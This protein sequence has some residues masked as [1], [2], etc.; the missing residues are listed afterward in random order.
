[1]FRRE[2]SEAPDLHPYI[3][4]NYTGNIRDVM[5]VAHELGHGIHQCLSRRVGILEDDAPLTMAETASVFGEML[6]FDKILE[7]EN[8]PKKRLALI[9]GKIDDN[10]ATVFRQIAMTDFEIKAHETGIQEGELSESRLNGLWIDANARM[11]G[12]S[13]TL[14]PSYHH[15]WKYIPHFIHTP[16]YCYAYAFAQLFVLTLYQKYKTQPSGFVPKYL[17]MLSLGGSKKPEEIARIMDLDIRDP[18][19]WKEGLGLLEN[20]VLEAETLAKE[21]G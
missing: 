18:H 1:L 14:T 3:L 21:V 7:D 6:I 11:Y 12:K 9:C 4:V 5:T 19:F 16:F 15:G 8:D 2:Q 20:L 10:F 13:V 17:E